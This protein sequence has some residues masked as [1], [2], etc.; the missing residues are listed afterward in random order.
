MG[1]FVLLPILFALVFGFAQRQSNPALPANTFVRRLFI[2]LTPLLLVVAAVNYLLNP[3]GLYDTRFFEPIILSSRTEKMRLYAE[4]AQPPQAL[5]LG[6]S[7]SFSVNPAQIEALWGLPT[8]NATVGA[9]TI[10]D[11]L[12]FTRYASH[13]RGTTPRLFIINLDSFSFYRDVGPEVEPNA[14]LWRYLDVDNPLLQLLTVWDRFNRL[15][16]LEQTQASW[17]LLEVERVG[18]PDPFYYFDADGWGHINQ[19]L[20]LEEAL[21]QSLQNNNQSNWAATFSVNNI[22]PAG[23]DALRQILEIARANQGQVI[24]YVPPMHPRFIQYLETEPGFRA[25][26]ARTTELFR[27]LQSDYPFQFMDFTDS[28]VFQQN[29]EANFLDGFH[30]TEAATR[31]MMQSLYDSFHTA[32]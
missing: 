32:P 1:A 4:L 28:P 30:P 15:F 3:L 17:R 23:I 8:F 25:M 26:Q 12:A 13:M 29:L 9:G 27:Q 2:A 22:T 7:R 11:G 10:F 31:L 20:T 18:R 16:T 6:S 24:G 21:V 5:I 14:N 19:A